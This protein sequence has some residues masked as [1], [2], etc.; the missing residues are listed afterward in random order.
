MRLLEKTRPEGA[1][2]FDR[3][4]ERF[5]LEPQGDTIAVGPTVRVSEMAVSVGA[6]LMELKDRLSI[7]HRPFVLGPAVGALAAQEPLY[8]RLLAST[9]FTAIIGW[10]RIGFERARPQG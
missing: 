3:G 10:G 7:L 1:G 2:A 4:I 5:R 8:Q 6:P 9:S